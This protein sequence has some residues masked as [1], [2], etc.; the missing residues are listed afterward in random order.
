MCV[1]YY[2]TSAANYLKEIC[3]VQGK[4]MLY[5]CCAYAYTY[6]LCVSKGW[7]PHFQLRAHRQDIRESIY[8]IIYCKYTYQVTVVYFTFIL[9]QWY[10][11]YITTAV[12]FPL[13]NPPKT[14][15]KNSESLVSKAGRLLSVIFY[16]GFGSIEHNYYVYYHVRTQR[17]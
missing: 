2:S 9:K 1:C 14:H 12:R 7:T 3:T 11:W 4:P 5:C 17:T 8:I 13:P 15:R 6:L 16:N 10:L